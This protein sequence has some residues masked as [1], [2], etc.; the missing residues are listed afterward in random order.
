[1]WGTLGMLSKCAN[2]V[3][4]EEFRSLR[5]GRLFVMDA[6]AAPSTDG[7]TAPVKRRP[8]RLEYF[9]LCHSCYKTMRVAVDT[10]HR[11]FVTSTL[12]ANPVSER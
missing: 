4:F 8:R 2:P 10:Y 7:T 9:W 1:M 6:G 12:R 3:C 5:E 11:V